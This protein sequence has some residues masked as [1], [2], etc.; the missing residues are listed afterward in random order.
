MSKKPFAGFNEFR[1][2][3]T[4]KMFF[5]ETSPGNFERNKT[6]RIKSN[7]WVDERYNEIDN[8]CFKL[9]DGITNLFEKFPMEIK[10]NLSNQEFLK[11]KKSGI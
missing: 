4:N 8:F 3:M 10:Q 7:H 1:R 6:F 11:S 5:E 9:R 2:R